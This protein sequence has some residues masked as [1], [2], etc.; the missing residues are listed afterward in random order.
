MGMSE[1]I[2]DRDPAHRRRVPQVVIGMALTAGL[3]VGAVSAVSRIDLARDSAEV[4]VAL[5][6]PAD[7]GSWLPP[8]ATSAVVAPE[9]APVTDA[10]LA[11]AIESL[12]G[13]PDRV[14]VL[15]IKGPRYVDG[16]PSQLERLNAGPPGLYRLQMACVGKG[17]IE[18]GPSNGFSNDRN[19]S[20][21]HDRIWI[22]CTPEPRVTSVDIPLESGQLQLY[23]V[24]YPKSIGAFAYTANQLKEGR[25]TH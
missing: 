13:A 14:G 9:P 22:T 15:I 3:V 21:K 1:D 17:A 20:A 18:V 12:P 11:K 5:A 7:S 2:I 10:Q 23:I 8:Q 4:R 16:S 24:I 6:T 25:T 19:E